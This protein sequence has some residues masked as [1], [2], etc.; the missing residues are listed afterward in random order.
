MVRIILTHSMKP[1]IANCAVFFH[2]L[3]N[4]LFV[5]S[6]ADHVNV[7]EIKTSM[8][9]MATLVGGEPP[10]GYTHLE[11]CFT[12]EPKLNTL[13]LWYNVDG[14]TKAVVRR[15]TGPAIAAN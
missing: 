10:A 3:K 9:E 12:F 5:F 14:T 1:T 8:V 6:H 4:R 2:V 13:I 15:V 11:E 7:N